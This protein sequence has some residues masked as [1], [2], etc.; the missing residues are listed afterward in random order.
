M[1]HHAYLQLLA[2]GR[3]LFLI[4]CGG[5]FGALIASAIARRKYRERQVYEISRR[6]LG[7]V[8]EGKKP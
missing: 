7:L 5:F 8:G 1:S 4:A 2:L 3:D 6:I